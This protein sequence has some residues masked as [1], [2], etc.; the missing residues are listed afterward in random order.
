MVRQWQKLYYKGRFSATDK[1]LHR[2]DFIKAAQADG[3]EF[4]VRLDRKA[5]TERVIKEFIE[6]DGPAFLEVIIDP[7]A[8]VFPMVGPGM[9]YDRMLTGN[10]IKSRSEPE[11]ED[12]IGP[13]SM[14]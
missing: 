6:F 7:D 10:F 14:F 9:A 3:F 2:K 1:S 11:G 13:S 5:D 4:A 8:M 12:E